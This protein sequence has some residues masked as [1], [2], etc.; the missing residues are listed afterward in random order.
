MSVRDT[1][2]TLFTVL[3]WGFNFVVIKWGIGDMSAAAMT[4]LRF[5]LVAFPLVFFVKK[6]STPL[7]VLA[8]YGILFGCG[9]WGLVNYA[10]SIGLPAGQS[11]L[12]LQSSAFTG[13]IAGVLFFGEKLSR[14]KR[15]GIGVAFIGFLLVAAVS[16]QTNTVLG[17]V[18]VF[19]AGLSMTACNMII[20]RYKPEDTL[21]FI[22]WS[23]LFVPIPIFAYLAFFTTDLS[24]ISTLTGWNGIMSIVFQAGVTTIIG[25]GIWTK[26]I[27]KYGLAP[28]TPF[29]LVVPISGIFFSWLFFAERPEALEILGSIFI[30][31]GLIFI[32]VPIG[33][34]TKIKV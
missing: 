15:L 31:T 8:T 33:Q 26:M 9:I 16:F 14:Q 20:R 30:L 10:I 21:S 22:V 19:M 23:S 24:N 7:I 3:L 34:K 6:P 18:L 32:S 29:A 1:L 2:L 13:A 12:L 17:M 5:S 27:A 11:S 4:A 28:I 25:Y